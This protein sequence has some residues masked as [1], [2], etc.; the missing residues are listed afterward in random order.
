MKLTPR[1]TLLGFI[2]LA[3]IFNS[4]FK[5]DLLKE[6]DA[7]KTQVSDMKKRNDSLNNV[8]NVR[9][10]S[11]SKALSNAQKRS[12]SLANVLRTKSDSLSLALGLTNANLANLTKSVDS[13]KTQ[14][15]TISGQ[16]T[17]LNLQLTS[18]TSQLTQLNQQLG[19][20]GGDVSQLAAQYQ[21]L[22]ASLQTINT[23]IAALQAEQLKLLEKLNAILIQLNPPQT[24]P[25]NGI[26]AY[27]RF[28]ENAGD[29]SGQNNHA[30]ISNA[31]YTTD[32]FGVPLRAIS[33]TSPNVEYVRTPAIINN[34]VNTF[35]IS[36][37]VSS[38][39]DDKLIPEGITGG[40]GYG[41]QAVLHPAHGGNWGNA[42]QNA[43]VGLFVG[44][45]QVAVV[46]HTH[47]FISAPLVYSTSLNG[48]HH[49][50]VVYENHIPKLY[51]DGV[52]V[53][54]G[55]ASAIMNVR[56]SNGTDINNGFGDY[57]TSGFGRAFSPSGTL[58]QFNGSID[59][60]RIYNRALTQ[61]EI[62]YLSKN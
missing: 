25:L 23:Q 18:I 1:K 58:A 48:W 39:S 4:C 54:V 27:Y 24:N 3:F 12:D 7:L 45:N 22:S 47:L 55:K 35:T 8:L 41:N 62:T 28:S 11:L 5:D 20:L 32:R 37:W 19:A 42:S 30:T 31:K 51:I 44:K 10:D 33:F 2:I 6:I 43:G 61:S 46:E 17:Q 60:F 53:K 36:C 50:T 34:V 26:L 52:F 9:A 21:A 57:S 59:D 49:I 29:S 16:L 56:P 14:I 13:I 40:E 38:L 15:A